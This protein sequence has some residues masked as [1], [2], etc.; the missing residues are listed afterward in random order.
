MLLHLDDLCACYGLNVVAV[1]SGKRFNN[2]RRPGEKDTKTR[3][4][5]ERKGHPGE[6]L[7]GSLIATYRIDHDRHWTAIRHVRPLSTA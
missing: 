2:I 1:L 6:Y 3:V 4:C 5:R 7:T